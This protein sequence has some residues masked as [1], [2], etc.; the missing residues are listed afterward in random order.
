MRRHKERREK[1]S[2]EQKNTKK[3][4][5]SKYRTQHSVKKYRVPRKNTDTERTNLADGDGEALRAYRYECLPDRD[6][7]K[8][9]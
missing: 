9:F 4:K 7:T 3:L 8:F 5:K 2:D 6:R 1:E